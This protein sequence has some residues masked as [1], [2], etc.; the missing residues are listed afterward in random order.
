MPWF[1][2]KSWACDMDGVMPPG[3]ME[4]VRS[5]LGELTLS[6]CWRCEGWEEEEGSSKSFCC[7]S[8]RYS[9]SGAGS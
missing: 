5:S 4:L 3:G 2:L 9:R 6:G 8:L 1:G 7:E